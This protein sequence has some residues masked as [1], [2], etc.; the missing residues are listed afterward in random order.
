MQN[1]D[2]IIKEAQKILND[3]DNAF[4]KACQEKWKR[5]QEEYVKF[6]DQLEQEH[7]AT[8]TPEEIGEYYRRK[9]CRHDQV[10]FVKSYYSDEQV[11]RGRCPDCD[12][13]LLELD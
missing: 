1:L 10:P 5:E 7:L 13:N 6:R 3:P 2:E 9:Y 12:C 4:M 11:Q 8:L